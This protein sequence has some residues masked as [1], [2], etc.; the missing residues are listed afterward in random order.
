M[1]KLRLAVMTIVTL[2]VITTAGSGAALQAGGAAGQQHRIH[3]HNGKLFVDD[4][5]SH[6]GFTVS[7]DHF[8]FL[9]FFVP[10]R[11]LFIVSDS[12][13]EGAT[14]SG[15]FNDSTISF[16]VDGTDI[17]IESSSPILSDSKAPAWVKFDPSFR[18]NVKS[19]ML[20]Y[21]DKESMPYEWPNQL[22]ES[23]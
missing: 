14:E 16:R 5:L 15:V 1:S 17:R 9:Y 23:R 10:A 13:F 20:G 6:H 12:Q 8:R 19:V 21:G 11:G 3:L 22:R 4:K 2:T 7:Q 18:L